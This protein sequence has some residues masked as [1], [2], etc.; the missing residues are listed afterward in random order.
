MP[1]PWTNPYALDQGVCETFMTGKFGDVLECADCGRRLWREVY[2]SDALVVNAVL[3]DGKLLCP[4]SYA[5]KIAGDA[6]RTRL[7]S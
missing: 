5:K 2:G 1:E 7:A 3:V 6:L 4:S